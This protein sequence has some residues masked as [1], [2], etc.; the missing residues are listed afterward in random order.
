MRIELTSP[1]LCRLLGLPADT[2]LS[3][4]LPV[5]APDNEDEPTILRVEFEPPTPEVPPC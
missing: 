5:G 3:L 2:K 1:A 4:G